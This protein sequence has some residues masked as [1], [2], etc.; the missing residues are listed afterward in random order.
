[1]DD[2]INVLHSNHM[3]SLVPC[4]QDANIIGNKEVFHMKR[5]SKGVAERYQAILVVK[6]FNQRESVDFKE[7]FSLV[8]KATTIKTILSIA[9]SNNWQLR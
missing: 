6:G 4:L 2:E 7:T 8:I 5:N 1:M 9:K 3:C